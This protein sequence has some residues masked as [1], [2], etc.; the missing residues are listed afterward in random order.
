VS[1]NVLT[2][3]Q[4]EFQQV[5][6]Q[7]YL[8]LNQLIISSRIP[9]SLTIWSISFRNF[10]PENFRQK[11]KRKKYGRTKRSLGIEELRNVGLLG[12]VDPLIS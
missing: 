9:A 8:Q 3:L 12:E 6:I 4:Q 1:Q 10:N 11:E 2:Q 5:Q 7:T